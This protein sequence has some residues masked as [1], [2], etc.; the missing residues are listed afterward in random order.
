ML[1]YSLIIKMAPFDNHKKLFYKNLTMI[2][3]ILY[4]R[5]KHDESTRY[6]FTNDKDKEV[7][8]SM[9]QSLY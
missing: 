7:I 2:K 6:V 9:V 1:C 8:G 5:R 3:H 4:V